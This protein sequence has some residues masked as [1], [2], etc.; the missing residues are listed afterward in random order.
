MSLLTDSL[1]VVSSS[2]LALSGFIK[3]SIHRKQFIERDYYELGRDSW[4]VV[5]RNHSV[6]SR[7]DPL[8]CH[9]S[10]TPTQ[11]LT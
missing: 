3:S 5:K 2:S 4:P 11:P 9:C 6:A 7:N 10:F 8:P 1:R